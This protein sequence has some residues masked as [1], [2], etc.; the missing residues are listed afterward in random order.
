[1]NYFFSM[2]SLFSEEI[3]NT[4][5][6]LPSPLTDSVMIFISTAGRFPVY[7]ILS[8]LVAWLYDRRKGLTILAAVLA[9]F[10]LNHLAKDMVRHPRP[11]PALLLYANLA[12]QNMP[13][14]FSFPSGHAQGAMAFFGSV[15][16]LFRNRLLCVMCI[17]MIMLV[18][19]SRLYLG[20]H[21]PGDV[22]GGL[23]LGSLVIPAISLY[24][25][26]R[27]RIKPGHG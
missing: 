12:L 26:I 25:F 6:V 8:C 14:S 27:T 3:L 11:D 19:F 15:A 2:H 7:I 1:M 23:V 22:A 4:L 20:V 24:R 17:S 21:F 13:K 16:I 18:S 9:T 10:A 5:H